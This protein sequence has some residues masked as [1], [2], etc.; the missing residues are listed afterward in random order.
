[1]KKL[2][3]EIEDFKTMID[4]NYYY[5]DKTM[6]IKEVLQQKITFL[7]RPNGFG[8]TLNLSMLYYFFS[9][10]QK[11]NN[12]LFNHLKIYEDR[13]AMNHQNIYPVISLSFKKLSGNN[14]DDLV[15][16]YKQLLQNWLDHN[17]PDYNTLLN[18]VTSNDELLTVLNTICD[19]LKNIYHQK[20]VILIDDYDTPLYYSSINDFDITMEAFIN[21][22][23]EQITKI[24]NL[25]VAV[26]TGQTTLK[27]EYCQKINLINNTVF[28]TTPTIYFGFNQ[29][30]VTN[31]LQT[32]QLI[33][34]INDI[35]QYFGGYYFNDQ[36]I[37]HPLWLLKGIYNILN[38]DS[39]EINFKLDDNWINQ[40][41]TNY[42]PLIKTE[43][44]KLLSNHTIIKKVN[45]KLSY[46]DLTSLN[47]I[48]SYFIY[49]GFLT[50]DNS[51]NH[52]LALQ[53]LKIPNLTAKQFYI[54]MLT[55]W[56]VNYIIKNR[57]KLITAL[58]NYQTNTAQEIINTIM[59]FSISP[60]HYSEKYY[61]DILA[62]LLGPL[63]QKIDNQNT[64]S[65]QNWQTKHIL[66][67]IS[68]HLTIC[69][70]RD[71]FFE[72]TKKKI[73]KNNYQA[74]SY[75]LLV[76]QNNCF[77]RLTNNNKSE[78]H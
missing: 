33:H 47:N 73:C 29:D 41:L 34:Q 38:N 66:K 69:N 68:I 25:F 28:T 52:Y 20:V 8:K 10:K 30:E 72:L 67:T 17:L 19:Y 7:C 16:A 13:K 11:Q 3:I 36:F 48:Y 32:Y 77:L 2:G 57:D 78:L 26:F 1:M 39:I 58:L 53:H 5:V 12:Y 50:D 74:L 23:I 31:L 18:F 54:N 27:I 61:Q 45:K 35:E 63:I 14:F 22:L 60:L 15:K 46:F 42:S 56:Q 70:Y 75:E 65:I 24:E 55:N 71:K 51:V 21:Q 4:D 76:Y 9:I 44:N 49:T 37:Y 6:W 43:L 40:Y 59:H 62:L 64:F